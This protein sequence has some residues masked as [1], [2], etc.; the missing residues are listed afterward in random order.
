MMQDTK[1]YKI[2]S[3]EN[4]FFSYIRHTSLYVLLY[5]VRIIIAPK[6]IIDVI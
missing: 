3:N 4:H 2:V 6:N 5:Y 1:L